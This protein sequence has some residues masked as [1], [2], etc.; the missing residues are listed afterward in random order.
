[1]S[2]I[3]VESMLA[4]SSI[5]RRLVVE[6]ACGLVA[7]LPYSTPECGGGRV[8]ATRPL[9]MLILGLLKSCCSGVG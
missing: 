5:L 9:H 2:V 3:I 7:A 6:A 4:E 1:M 8:E